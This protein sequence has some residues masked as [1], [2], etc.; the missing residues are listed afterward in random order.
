MALDISGK[1][2]LF[3][4]LNAEIH[5]NTLDLGETIKMN[6]DATLQSRA[7]TMIFL[8]HHL[9]ERLKIEYPTIFKIHLFFDKI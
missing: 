1:N 9:D 7:K 4:I 3:W 2:Y 6:N 8:R 5:L